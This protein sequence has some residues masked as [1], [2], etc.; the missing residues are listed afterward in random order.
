M[1]PMGAL[2]QVSDGR[3]PSQPFLKG[4]KTHKVGGTLLPLA[5]L[6]TTNSTRGVD[7]QCSAIDGHPTVSCWRRVV[8]GSSHRRAGGY[9]VQVCNGS[10]SVAFF[11]GHWAPILS[12]ESRP[13]TSVPAAKAASC[14]SGVHVWCLEAGRRLGRGGGRRTLLRWDVTASSPLAVSQ[15]RYC[16]VSYLVFSEVKALERR[17][18]AAEQ[19]ME[20]WKVRWTSGCHVLKR[21]VVCQ[22]SLVLTTHPPSC[23]L[24]HGARAAAAG[25]DCPSS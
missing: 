20:M 17:T 25:Q 7:S 19:A 12:F 14:D 10:F 23:C 5:V 16:G 6:N 3:E 11:T 22:G 2:C 24:W 8:R 15:P 21:S 18:L 9:C 1:D 4:V 13:L